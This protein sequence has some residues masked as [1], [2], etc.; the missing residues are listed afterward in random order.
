MGT[1]SEEQDFYVIQVSQSQTRR[2]QGLM[3]FES[4][5]VFRGQ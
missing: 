1:N 3:Q 2:I 5:R 4:L